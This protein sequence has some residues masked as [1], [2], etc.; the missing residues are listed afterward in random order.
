MLKKNPAPAGFFFGDERLPLTFVVLASSMGCIGQR[1]AVRLRKFAIGLRVAGDSAIGDRRWFIAL[2]IAALPQSLIRARKSHL[3]LGLCRIANL[4][5]G[6]LH[7]RSNPKCL[8]RILSENGKRKTE[9]GKRKTE[10][11]KRKPLDRDTIWAS[12]RCYPP[13]CAQHSKVCS[14]PDGRAELWIGV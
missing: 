11:G 5:A 1:A 10:N 14:E 9:N 2:R 12:K 7:F 6:A 13:G 4:T 8:A 3:I